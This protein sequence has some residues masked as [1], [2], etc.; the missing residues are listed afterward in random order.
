[1]WRRTGIVLVI[2]VLM[3]HFRRARIHA[4]IKF[5]FVESIFHTIE[6]KRR[7][8]GTEQ[9]DAFFFWLLIRYHDIGLKTTTDAEIRGNDILRDK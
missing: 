2:I 4:M 3:T 6:N 9:K 5:D 1:M 7:T 8:K